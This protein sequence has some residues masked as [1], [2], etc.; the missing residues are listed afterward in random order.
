MVEQTPRAA[1]A[2]EPM[3]AQ[4]H[5]RPVEGDIGRGDGVAERTESWP[6]VRDADKNGI[7]CQK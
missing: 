2:S 4:C 6:A 1:L 3:R 7:F 5:G